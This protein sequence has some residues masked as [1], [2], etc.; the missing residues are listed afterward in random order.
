VATISISIF[1]AYALARL[2]PPFSSFFLM[3]LEHYELHLQHMSPHSITQV[4]IF[5]HFDEMLVGVRPS[6]SLFQL[7]HVMR[8]MNRQPLDEGFFEVPR[9]SQPWQ[10][11]A[12][13]GGLGTGASRCPRSSTRSRTLT[14]SRLTTPRWARSGSWLRAGSHP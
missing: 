6:V 1:P 13:E 10:V 3:L 14:W 7:F 2:V 5:T 4:A 12:L 9:R 11:G 8:P